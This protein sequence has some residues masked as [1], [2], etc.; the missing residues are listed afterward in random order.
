MFVRAP[1]PI[2]PDGRA[3]FLMVE[4][5][6]VLE[7]ISTPLGGPTINNHLRHSVSERK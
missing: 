6:M 7:R 3:A 5:A 2:D 4:H 1:E